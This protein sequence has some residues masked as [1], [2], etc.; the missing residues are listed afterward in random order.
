[1]SPFKLQLGYDQPR[2]NYSRDYKDDKADE[3]EL[4]F[5]EGLPMPVMQISCF[6]P[7]GNGTLSDNEFPSKQS[8]PVG[9]IKKHCELCQVDLSELENDQCTHAMSN[10]GQLREG[11]MNII[12]LKT[13]F[14][15]PEDTLTE[16]TM[17]ANTVLD[18]SSYCDGHRRKRG[19][20][21]WKMVKKIKFGF[22]DL[23]KHCIDSNC[24]VQ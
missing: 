11:N 17:A 5:V 7:F 6:S 10:N 21:G 15:R 1:M 2:I 14:L 22:L 23:N 20:L 19:R 4:L 9:A 13:D 16:S 18:T 12:G 8:S 3:F 24:Q